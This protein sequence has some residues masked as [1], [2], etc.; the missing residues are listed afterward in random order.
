[1]NKIK[2]ALICHFSVPQIRA[3]LD[4]YNGKKRNYRDYGLWNVN[5]INGLKSQDN[6]ELHVIVPHRGMKHAIQEFTLDNVFYHFFWQELPFPWMQIEQKLFPQSK[7]NFPRNRKIVKNFIN[8]IK[9]D[10]VNLIGAENPYYSITALDVSDAP[11]ILH[12][13]TVYANPDRIRNTGK[14]VQQRWDVELQLFHHIPYIA[15]TGRMY[16]DLIKGYEPRAIMFPRKWP[17]SKYP[18][19]KDVPPKYDFA[20]F[21]RYLSKNK[22]F[23]NAIEAIAKAIKVHPEM[24]ILA[25]GTWDGDRDYFEK[26]IDE[27]GIRN[28]IEIHSSFSEYTDMLQYV[29][30]ARFALLPIKMDVLSGTI[31]EALS[32]GMPVVT[33][34]TSGT[35]SLNKKR[36]TVLIS[37]IGDDEALANNMLKLYESHKLEVKLRQNGIIYIKEW[38]EEN[39]HNV[40]EMVAQYKAVIAHYREG[41]PIPRELL[42]DTEENIDYRKP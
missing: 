2:V 24:K 13:Q 19:I 15:C 32:M 21:A 18:V 27:L 30:Q 28:N 39:E 29:K 5:I 31:M 36:E 7:R 14:I 41:T 6:I 16:Y 35:P 20:Y 26:M 38:E 8:K 23:D 9:P 37:D 40:E 33:C 12:C 17:V 42:Y 22:G 25:V 34:R 11:V 10:I 1:M 4:L 3:E